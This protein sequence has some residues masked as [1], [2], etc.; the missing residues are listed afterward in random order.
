MGL[1]SDSSKI[2]AITGD[3]KKRVFIG[4]CGSFTEVNKPILNDLKKYLQENEYTHV[5]TAED[6]PFNKSPIEGGDAK[7]GYAY[8]KSMALVNTCNIIIVFFFNSN[9]DCEVNQ[10]VDTEIQ[11]LSSKEKRNVIILSEEDF[12]FRSNI[13][14]I[15]HKRSKWWDWETFSRDNLPDC[16]LYVKQTCHNYILERFVDRDGEKNRISSLTYHP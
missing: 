10:S 1:Y 14:G 15:R 5:F 6:F 16:Y 3:I 2:D 12:R 7:Y 8:E 4:I 9:H 11:E 13:K